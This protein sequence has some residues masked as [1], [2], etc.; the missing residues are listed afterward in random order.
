LWHAVMGDWSPGFKSGRSEDCPAS[1][2][3]WKDAAGFIVRL[4]E[5]TGESF[6]LPTEAEWEY[7]ARGGQKSKGYTYS[8]SNKADDVAWYMNTSDN[9][10]H[11]VATKLPNELGIYDMSG[12]VWECVADKR[13]E[14]YTA[15][16]SGTFKSRGGGFYQPESSVRISNRM[17][18]KHGVRYDGL[19]MR[20]A[21]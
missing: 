12:N 7:A 5:L 1:C 3:T 6:R 15:R 2:L 13:D 14:D 19:G 11:P 16:K 18:G 8:G 21:M 10:I 17:G 4:N 20:L 9:V